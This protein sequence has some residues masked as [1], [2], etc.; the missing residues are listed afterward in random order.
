MHHRRKGGIPKLPPWLTKDIIQ[1]MAL[2][3]KLKRDELFDLFKKKKKK[4]KQS[5]DF[6]TYS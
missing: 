3:D 5:V 1:A 2:R 4:E 6:G